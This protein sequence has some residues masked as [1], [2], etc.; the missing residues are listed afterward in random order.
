M[1]QVLFYSTDNKSSQIC[2]HKVINY[3]VFKSCQQV[4]KYILLTHYCFYVICYKW[5]I[6]VICHHIG[7]LCLDLDLLFESHLK[8]VNT[9]ENQTNFTLYLM[10]F[11]VR[12]CTKHKKDFIIIVGDLYLSFGSLHVGR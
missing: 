3:T 12:L 5:M 4:L 10:I 6:K 1:N 8:F 2:D 7:L 9:L 11:N